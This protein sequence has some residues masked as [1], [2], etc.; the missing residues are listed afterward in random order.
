[1][2]RPG[3]SQVQSQHPDSSRGAPGPPSVQSIQPGQHPTSNARRR[4][5]GMPVEWRLARLFVP[6]ARPFFRAPAG[7]LSTLSFW[8]CLSASPVICL[9]TVPDRTAPP[10]PDRT[11]PFSRSRPF[12]PRF[13]LSL[14]LSLSSLPKAALLPFSLS[15]APFCFLPSSHLVHFWFLHSFGIQCRPCAVVLLC[16]SIHTVRAPY[17]LLPPVPPSALIPSPVDWISRSF[18]LVTLFWSASSS[19]RISAAQSWNFLGKSCITVDL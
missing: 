13:S 5:G 1:M 14:S 19:S 11:T 7:S 2:E 10:V 6:L 12:L 18:S 3:S 4:Q 9:W 8:R 17:I 15:L 16:P